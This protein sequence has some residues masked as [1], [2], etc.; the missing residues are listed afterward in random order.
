MASREGKEEIAHGRYSN[1]QGLSPNIE[2]YEQLDALYR[3]LARAIPV[4]VE[5]MMREQGL[6]I[7]PL[8]FRAFDFETDDW[9]K[10]KP[11]KLYANGD[12]IT[13]GYQKEPITIT[14]K[15]KVQKKSFP[16]FKMVILDN[17]GSMVEGINGNQ[18]NT[19]YIPWGDNSKYHYALLGFYGIEQFLQAQGIAQYI[20]HGL[21]LFSSSTRYKETDYKDLQKLRKLALSPKFQGTRID[22][23]MLLEAL[24]GRESFVVSLSDGEIKNWDRV[25]SE[26]E[27]LAKENYFAHIQIGPKNQ[28]TKDLESLNLP[29]FYINSGDELSKLMVTV[30]TN[31]YKEFIRK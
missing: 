16:D 23:N 25:K 15:S 20:G 24:R 8:N 22:A 17:S 4:Q 1:D 18:G 10:V 6:I 11:T 14:V 19:T 31:T 26:F 30:A 12:G 3:K 5:A 21:S 28:F 29:V 7:G 9:R 2:S 27:K 13:L